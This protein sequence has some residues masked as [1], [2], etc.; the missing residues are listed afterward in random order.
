MIRALLVAATVVVAAL[1]ETID[2]TIPERAPA[3]VLYDVA[4]DQADALTAL[5]DEAPTLERLELAPLVLGRMT[6]V[7]GESLRGSVDARRVIES[8]DEHKLTHRLVNVDEVEVVRGAWWPAGYSGPP[9]VAF[10]DREAD[11]IHQFTVGVV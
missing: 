1:L 10:E 8:S 11:Q 7:D 4:V 3:L 2:D 5:A 9:L 6:H